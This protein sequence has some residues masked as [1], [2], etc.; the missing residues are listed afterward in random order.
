MGKDPPGRWSFL[1]HRVPHS[2]DARR[3][4]V[5]PGA[6]RPYDEAEWLD[7]VVVVELGEIELEC[8][9]GGRRRFRAGDILWLVGLPL[10]ALHCSGSCPAVLLAVSRLATD[11]FSA[12]RPS[13]TE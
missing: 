11:E 2:F 13:E 10:R 6:V 3:V 1:G 7:A 4:V 12:T 5:Q 8:S 9:R